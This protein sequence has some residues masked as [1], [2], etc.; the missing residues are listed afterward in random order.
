MLDARAVIGEGDLP[1]TAPVRG[2]IRLDKLTFGYGDNGPVLHDITLHL[3]AGTK[4]GIVGPVGS[5]KSTLARLIARLFPVPEGT[6]FIDGIDINR[7]RLS[8]LRGAIG[9]VPQEGFLFSRSIRENIACGREG[10]TE[11]EIVAAASLAQLNN[12]IA[13]F[14]DGYD[15]QVGERGVTLSGGQK[16]RTAIA[17]ALLAQPP[18][19]ILDDPLSSVD[20]ATEEA[21]LAGLEKYYGTRT[22]IIVSHRLSAVQGCDR[23]VLLEEGRIKEEGSPAELLAR[24]GSYAAL[25]REQQLRQEIERL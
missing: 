7:M 15:T 4:T 20:A 13:V 10:A 14:P 8:D 11:E 24:G 21:I 3:P 18:I 25:H 9:F 1:L 5:G 17:R 2:E 22:V 23:I 12:E 6:L 19:L 16:Q